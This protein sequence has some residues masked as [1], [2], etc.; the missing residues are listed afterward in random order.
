MTAVEPF[1]VTVA[2]GRAMQPYTPPTIA[3]AF[4]AMARAELRQGGN[5][6][7]IQYTVKQLT[8]HL[9]AESRD[10]WWYSL[11]HRLDRLEP[12]CGVGPATDEAGTPWKDLVTE[13]LEVL[14]GAR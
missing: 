6:P 5:V 2:R 13:A 1:E 4:T 9:T 11:K 10:V 7:A 12:A 8:P 14:A 3:D